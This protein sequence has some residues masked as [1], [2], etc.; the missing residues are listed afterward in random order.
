MKVEG[1]VMK[2]AKGR[3]INYLRVSVTDR[4]NFRC[5]Y[6]M[7]EEGINQKSHDD[8]LRFEEIVEFIKQVVPLGITNVR[9]TGGEPLVR[10]GIVDFVS[11]VSKI[12][13]IQDISMTTNGSLLSKYAKPLKRAGLDRVNI[14]LDSLDESKFKN[15][16]RRGDLTSVHKGIKSALEAGLNPVKI[17]CVLV[18]G[19]NDDEISDFVNLTIDNSL[20]VRFIELMP[21]G[22]DQT[23]QKRFI[24]AKEARQLVGKKLY[25]YKGK[26]I[27][28]MGP[29]KYYKV[30]DSKGAVG[31]IT[32]ISSHFCEKC[33]RIRLTA[34]GKLKPCLESDLEV[35][36]KKSL[37]E[38]NYQEVLYRFRQALQQKP[39]CHHMNEK[40]NNK[41]RPV[42][43]MWQIGG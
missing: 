9:I 13:G 17:N 26:G 3:K 29:A 23:L 41:N 40:G 39:M 22:G 5:V 42:R 36:I 25:P 4:C 19:F 27:K 15:V 6:C 1:I 7:P 38:G 10:K 14:S 16:T 43:S 37:K 34:D 12:K 24:S 21:L 28:G 8:I 11:E 35:D 18:R 20:Y 30:S 33:N 2:D 32:P 31:F